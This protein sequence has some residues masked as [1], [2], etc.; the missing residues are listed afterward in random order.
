MEF[1]VGDR[2]RIK[3]WE[4]MQKEFGG[5]DN[6]IFCKKDFIAPMKYLCGRTATISKITGSD[7]SLTDWSNSEGDPYRWNYSTD[8]V[9]LVKI[10]KITKEDLREGDILTDREGY[11]SVVVKYDTHLETKGYTIELYELTDD[12][13]DEGGNSNNDIVRVERPRCCETIFEREEIRKM[14]VEEI[15]KELGYEVKVV[16]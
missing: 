10:K 5:N 15:S 16:K 13:L 8:M 12:L 4:Q 2:V 14:T 7:I 1:K 9:E 11:Q 6:K 3:S